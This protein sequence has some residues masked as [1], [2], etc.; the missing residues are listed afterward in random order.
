MSKH[1][2]K[3]QQW[4]K[5]NI[6]NNY[7]SAFKILENGNYDI[8]LIEECSCENN[9]QLRMKERE[10]IDKLNCVN[11]LKPYINNDEKKERDKNYNHKYYIQII[12]ELKKTINCEC[13]SIIQQQNY[14][15]H[16]KRQKHQSYLKNQSQINI[17]TDS[18]NET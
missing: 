4:I 9:E 3:Y 11:I 10:W 2:S 7:Y 5:D 15:K 12:N 1:K 6:N 13:G 18:I 17:L 14:N 16:C 8:I